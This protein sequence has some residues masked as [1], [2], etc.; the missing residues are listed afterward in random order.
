M[1]FST[2]QDVTLQHMLE[3]NKHD[4]QCSVAEVRRLGWQ[5]SKARCQ[6]QTF[7]SNFLTLLCHEKEKKN[8]LHVLATQL[9]Q[10]EDGIVSKHLES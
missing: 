9:L 5:K 8:N 2:L 10:L 4:M 3:K 7:K 6:I 1:A